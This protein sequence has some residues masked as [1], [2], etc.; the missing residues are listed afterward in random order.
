MESGGELEPLE[1]DGAW[2][3]WV[4]WRVGVAVVLASRGFGFARGSNERFGWAAGRIR[5]DVQIQNGGGRFGES[6]L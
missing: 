5:T 2:T 6:S 3:A 1:L 4:T